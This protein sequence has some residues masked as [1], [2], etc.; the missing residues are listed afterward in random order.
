MCILILDRCAKVYFTMHIRMMFRYEA[1]CLSSFQEELVIMLASQFA[2]QR[3]IQLCQPRLSILSDAV[4]SA[5]LTP[6]VHLPQARVLSS[7][8]IVSSPDFACPRALARASPS[9]ALAA[10]A[11]HVAHHRGMFARRPRPP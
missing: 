7:Q 9:I 11:A 5:I 10:D 2:Y 1:N 4:D 3:P 6:R 8:H